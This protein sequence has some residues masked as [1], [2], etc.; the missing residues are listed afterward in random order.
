MGLQSAI[1]LLRFV[2]Q[3]KWVVFDQHNRFLCLS[4]CNLVLRLSLCPH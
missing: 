4:M 3:D 2:M 1:V